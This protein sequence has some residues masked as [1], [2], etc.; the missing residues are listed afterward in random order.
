MNRNRVGHPA[1]IGAALAAVLAAGPVAAQPSV[2]LIGVENRSAGGSR[3]HCE[4]TRCYVAQG[5]TLLAKLNANGIGGA[6]HVVDGT[7]DIASSLTGWKSGTN[8]VE[9]KVTPGANASRGQ[10]TL[11]VQQRAPNGQVLIEWPFRVDVVNNGQLQPVTLPTYSNFVTE[12]EIVINGSRLGNAK[13]FVPNT[14]PTPRPTLTRLSSSTDSQLRIRAVWSQAQSNPSVLFTLCDEAYSG[15]GCVASWGTVQGKVTTPAAVQSITC[16]PNPAKPG[17]DMEIT[18][19]LTAAARPAG[20]VLTWK[21]SSPGDFAA[22]AGSCA[23]NNQGLNNAVTVAGG[24]SLHKCKVRVV[25][26]SGAGVSPVSRTID[27]WMGNTSS[28]QA[29]WYKS[30]SCQLKAM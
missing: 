7:S 25:Q 5:H 11:K 15:F 19:Q 6:T 1:R 28:L 14:A 16:I 4:G 27:T 26:A 22:V 18:F 23:Y 17:D 9:V 3:T 20:D 10:R 2:N 30:A 29:P 12:A 8:F 13:I 24:N 21:I